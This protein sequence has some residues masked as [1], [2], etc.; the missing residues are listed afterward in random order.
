MFPFDLNS[1]FNFSLKFLILNTVK[2]LY[3]EHV[4]NWFLK[5]VY[6]ISMIIFLKT[7]YLYECVD[8]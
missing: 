1:K 7:T 3:V 2:P 4:D 6:I 5:L 8:N